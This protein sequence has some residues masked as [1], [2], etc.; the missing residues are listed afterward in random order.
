MSYLETYAQWVTQT[1]GDPQLQQELLG[2]S[3]DLP[4]IE[5]RFYRELE[6][7]TG[8]LRG[9]MGAGSNRMNRYTVAKATQ[10]YSSYLRKNWERPSVAIGYDSR[11]HSEAFARTAAA[12]FAANGVIVR[13][14][15]RL[16]PTPA[17]SFAVRDLG[18][19]GGVVITASHNPAEYN[20]YKVYGSDGCQ[21][22]TR[23]AREIQ[24]EI[25]AVHP[26][27]DVKWADF[28]EK[29]AQG[30]IHCI[31][32]ETVER[33]LE[34]VSAVSLLPADTG[35]DLKIVYTPLN[36]AGISCVP[37]CLEAHGF[38]GLILPEEQKTP[39][40]QIGRAHV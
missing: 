15:P 7:G 17:L 3:G 9:V 4:A 32:E 14:Y 5:E 27:F 31:G 24:R 1:A 39:D 35:R 29:L 25:D 36:G 22:T 30:W 26:F 6:F 20:G 23:T 38:T 34:A 40:G 28:E 2:L 21:I 13:L 19:S 37:L 33:Y 8:G 18:C 11:L 12:V 16:M 10:G